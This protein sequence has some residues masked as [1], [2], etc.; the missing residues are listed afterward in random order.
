MLAI[1][2]NRYPREVLW[3]IIVNFTM[4][5]TTFPTSDPLTNMYS[6]LGTPK[7]SVFFE[8]KVKGVV[9]FNT[10]NMGTRC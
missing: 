1:V 6:I 5:G 4:K 3:G 7:S 2:F 8:K 10:L 9:S